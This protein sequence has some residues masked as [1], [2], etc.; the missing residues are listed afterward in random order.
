MFG[1]L[2]TCQNWKNPQMSTFV[3]YDKENALEKLEEYKRC[4][5]TLEGRV[6]TII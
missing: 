6:V 3:F 5:N 4:D 2:Y 1:I